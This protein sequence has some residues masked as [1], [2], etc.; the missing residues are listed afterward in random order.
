MS[1]QTALIKD[2]AKLGTGIG[3]QLDSAEVTAKHKEVMDS[4]WYP[5][6]FDRQQTIKPPSGGTFRWIFDE[7]PP[8]ADPKQDEDTQLQAHMRGKFSRWLRNDEPLFWISGKAG[9]GKSSLMS[10]IQD[11]SRTT[12]ALST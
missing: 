5:E 9:S 3:E 11:D 8:K 4:L 2:F 7:S 1:V 10:L 12:Q 6:I